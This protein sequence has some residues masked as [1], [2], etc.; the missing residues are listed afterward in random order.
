MQDP[1]LKTFMIFLAV[2]V[3]FM[4]TNVVL[5]LREKRSEIWI[6]TLGWIIILPPFLAAAYLG[7]IFFLAMIM[8]I[9]F[10][11]TEEFYFLA[12]RSSA[13]V[14]KIAGIT[15]S[16]LLPMAAFIGG[17]EIFHVVA[18]L[19]ALTILTLPIYKQQVKKDVSA[20][21][22]TSSATIL[23]ML[24]VGWTSSYLILIRNLGNG[25]EYFLLFYVLILANDNFSHYIGRIIG[26]TKFFQAISPNKTLEGAL[27][28]LIMTLVFAYLLRFLL[29]ALELRFVLLLGIII[30]VSGQLGDLVESSLKREA[31]V[32]DA[33]RF[34][35]GIGGMLDRFDSLIFSAPIA[36]LFAVLLSL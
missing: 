9:V 34:L 17:S 16:V 21:I 28:G 20:N 31:K 19:F 22:Q 6:R 18:I 33:G 1:I 8:L 36:Y 32:K 24:Y 27:G 12:E 30:A 23:G 3:I 4:L 25:L 35:P 15:L 13:G 11:G 7:G 26:R 29:P 14:Y 5:S 10:L 2:F